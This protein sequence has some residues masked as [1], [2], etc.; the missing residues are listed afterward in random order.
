MIEV[1]IGLAAERVGHGDEPGVASRDVD[2]ARATV[3]VEGSQLATVVVLVERM[4]SIGVGDFG[5]GVL[6]VVRVLDTQTV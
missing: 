2:A 6:I 5:Q 4:R 1:E 3:G